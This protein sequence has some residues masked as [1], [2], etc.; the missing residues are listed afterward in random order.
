[1]LPTGMAKPNITLKISEETKKKVDDKLKSANV[2]RLFESYIV[3][4]LNDINELGE[5]IIDS[6][7][8]GQIKI[9]YYKFNRGQVEKI[10]S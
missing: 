9:E 2:S 6:A 5:A 8:K 1:M 4:L 3:T 7:E 10:E